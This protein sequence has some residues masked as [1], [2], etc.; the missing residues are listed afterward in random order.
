MLPRRASRVPS[1][2]L[3]AP[4]ACRPWA[5]VTTSRTSSVQAA[6]TRTPPPAPLAGRPQVA[7]S[8]APACPPPPPPKETGCKCPAVMANRPRGQALTL[9]W[10]DAT[11]GC[12]RLQAPARPPPVSV[13]RLAARAAAPP[14]AA[15]A[16]SATS[17]AMAAAAAPAAL[18]A[19][20]APAVVAPALVGCPQGLQ[21]GRARRT[22]DGLARAPPRP[23][24]ARAC[25]R[26]PPPHTTR[27]PALLLCTRHGGAQACV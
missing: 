5:A 26:H 27:T 12:V 10:P 2:Q 21:V 8:A 24:D 22:G 7:K 13:P 9:S 23:G 11:P 19:P 25:R 14:S 16:T 18:A 3:A 17:R 4:C 20:A 15:P 1:G 6:T